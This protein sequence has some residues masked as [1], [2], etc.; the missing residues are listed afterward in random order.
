MNYYPITTHSTNTSEIVCFFSLLFFLFRPLPISI[1]FFYSCSRKISIRP[2]TPQCLKNNSRVVDLVWF[3]FF[4]FF[5][6]L[7]LKTQISKQNLPSSLIFDL[8]RTEQEKKK[9]TKETKINNRSINV[10]WAETSCA[11]VVCVAD[12]AHNFSDLLWCVVW[13]S[14]IR[15]GTR[16]TL[17]CF[18]LLQQGITVKSTASSLLAKKKKDILFCVWLSRQNSRFF[19]LFCL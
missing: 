7:S 3:F 4:V 9:K 18:S 11:I 15:R 13:E 12:G 19:F 8:L 1:V 14:F 6:L 16:L 5:F 17:G 2:W 10:N